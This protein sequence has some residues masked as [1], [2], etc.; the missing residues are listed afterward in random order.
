M[1]GKMLLGFV[2]ILGLFLAAMPAHAVTA[3]TLIGAIASAN[4]GQ[5]YEEAQLELACS[6]TVT[7][8]TNVN[9][10]TFNTSGGVNYIDVTPNTPGYFLL[11][12]GTGNTGNDMF[13]FQNIAEL[14]LLAWTDAQLTGAGLPAD[15]L[16]SISHY[17]ITTSTT[18]TP[19]PA[20]LMLLGA[21]LAGIGIWRRKLA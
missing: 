12:F 19:E 6:C 3:D 5:A 13:F 1:K 10:S 16:S 9:T 20:S 2:A 4:S 18:T 21:G 14:N 11:K 15:H 7:L 8:L 17:A